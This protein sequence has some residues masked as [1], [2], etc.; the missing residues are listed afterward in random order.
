MPKSY[1][2]KM[3]TIDFHDCGQSP[4][5]ILNNPCRFYGQAIFHC[6]LLPTDA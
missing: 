1:R 4:A 6:L 2:T 3:S 5:R